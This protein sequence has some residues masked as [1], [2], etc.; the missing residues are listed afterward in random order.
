MNSWPVKI[1]VAYQCFLFYIGHI[2]AKNKFRLDQILMPIDHNLRTTWKTN[3]IS[4]N[5]NA[6]AAKRIILLA[7]VVLLLAVSAIAQPSSRIWN[8]NDASAGAQPWVA[9]VRVD[10]AHKCGGSIISD[11]LVLTAGSCVSQLGAVS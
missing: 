5:L 1:Q 10:G 11:K 4:S 2:K 7:A 8:G 6:M 3:C 9:S